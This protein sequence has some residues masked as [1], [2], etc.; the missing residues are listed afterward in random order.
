[1]KLAPSGFNEQISGNSINNNNLHKI[2]LLKPLKIV[3][4]VALNMLNAYLYY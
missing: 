4:K 1:M 3:F 2:N